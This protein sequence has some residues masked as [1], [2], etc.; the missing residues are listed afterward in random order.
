MSALKKLWLLLFFLVWFCFSY[1]QNI[2]WMLGT[3]KGTGNPRTAQ[4]VKTLV[5]ESVAGN[6]FI[7]SR[8]KEANDHNHSKIVTAITGEIGKDTFYIK[9]VAITFKKDPPH[10]KW[11]DCTQC[12]PF[13]KVTINGDSIL[14]SSTTSNCH[15]LC[16]GVT[17]YFKLIPDF[18]TA[19]Q[20]LVVEIFGT[21]EQI[22][23]FNSKLKNIPSIASS[24]PDAVKQDDAEVAKRQKQIN[25]S[26]EYAAKVAQR[27]RQQEITDSLKNAAVIA[28]QQKQQ[29]DDSIK[30]A[31]KRQQEIDDSLQNVALLK[32]QREKQIDDSLQTVA[33]IAKQ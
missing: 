16:N 30:I 5:I 21:P 13:N 15:P 9:D 26:L 3:W 17:T 19:T 14:L 20:R 11:F 18:D 25:D 7:G 23:A 6:N 27:K 32:T 12:I 28:K 24:D 1:S 4:F 10:D 29:Y 2:N 31:K 8:S 33:N 22:V